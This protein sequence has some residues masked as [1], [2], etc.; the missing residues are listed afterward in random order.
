[1]CGNVGEDGTKEVAEWM[2]PIREFDYVFTDRELQEIIGLMDINQGDDKETQEAVQ[3][4]LPESLSLPRAG[5]QFQ[6]HAKPQA[7]SS[8]NQPPKAAPDPV[9]KIAPNYKNSILPCK[10]S[11]NTKP[12]V[13]HSLV[14]KQRRDRIN[15]LIDELRELVPPQEV[16]PGEPMDVK[17]PKHI[18][19]SDTISLLRR[20]MQNGTLDG[21]G[22]VKWEQGQERE[23]TSNV[24]GSSQGT[25]GEGS[26][27][28]QGKS[29]G[30]TLP[31]QETIF[32]DGV[33]VEAGQGCL[34]IKINCKDRRG[35][36]SDIITHLR[37]M[38]LEIKSAA[39]TTTAESCVMD[40]FEVVLDAD[41]GLSAQDVQ[42]NMQAFLYSS[43]LESS[44]DKRRRQDGET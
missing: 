16:Q 32:A 38:P 31:L 4:Q 11:I 20:L 43:N 37:R 34:L 19:L 30:M 28:M 39:V 22:F 27:D 13:S 5:L 40:V 15:S 7:G 3:A 33:T 12:T 23:G 8:A 21:S 18:V 25:F 41:S 29:S 2:D 1:M 17:R 36:L 26:G 14:E 35:L 6:P 9:K 24:A 42:C 44:G 10:E